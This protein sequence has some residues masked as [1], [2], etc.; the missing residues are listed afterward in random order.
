MLIWQH[1]KGTERHQECFKI[2]RISVK[3][4]KIHF[5]KS[6]KKN[7]GDDCW[8]WSKSGA[9]LNT[10]K[11]ITQTF[12]CIPRRE[13]CIG[14]RKSVETLQIVSSLSDDT[15]SVT[16]WEQKKNPACGIWNWSARIQW[17]SWEDMSLTWNAD[18]NV[19]S[20][21]RAMLRGSFKVPRPVLCVSQWAGVAD[22]V[23]IMHVS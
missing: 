14:K 3:M 12:P 10:Q 6:P 8:L 7:V 2:W 19:N 18:L 16:T 9:I 15:K 20:W 4:V 11:H 21:G 5:Y 17:W 22:V 13:L 1:Q 23:I